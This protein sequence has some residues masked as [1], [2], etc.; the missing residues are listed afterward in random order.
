MFIYLHLPADLRIGSPTHFAF[1]ETVAVKDHFLLEDG[2]LL[3]C[4]GRGVGQKVFVLHLARIAPV[5]K[6]LGE[7]HHAINHAVVQ[8]D[9]FLFVHTHVVPKAEDATQSFS[10]VGDSLRSGGVQ[11]TTAREQHRVVVVQVADE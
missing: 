8:G 9:V 3:P 4:L 2:Q 10:C 11:E 7:S 6:T 1:V 5:P